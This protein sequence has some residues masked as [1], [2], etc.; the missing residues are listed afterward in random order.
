M[1]SAAALIAT[2]RF[3]FAP[4][5][6]ELATVAREPRGWVRAQLDLPL[7]APAAPLPPSRETVTATLEAR[8]LKRQQEAQGGTGRAEMRDELRRVYL[9]EVGARMNAA[10]FSDAPLQERLVH[11]WSN[12][13]TV[14]ALRPVVRGFVGA[15]E[16]EAIRPHVTGRFSDMLL[17]VARHPAMLF[18]LDNVQSIGPDS[19]VGQRRAKGLN[20]NL[21]REILELHTL[22]VDGGYTQADVES[23]AR[24]LTGW[25]IARPNDPNP[26]SFRFVPQI[27]EP[28]AKTL[29][30]KRYADDG[31]AEGEAALRDLARHPATA[32]HIA[33]KLAIHFIADDPPPAAVERIAR[34]FRDSDGDLKRVMQ[35]V[36]DS[37]EA[38][39]RPFAKVR[40][41]SELVIAACRIADL[42]PPPQGIVQSL[43]VLDQPPFVA[44][45]PAG[46]PDTASAWIS[47]ESVVRRAEW[48]QAFADRL[49]DPPD[50]VEL[51]AETFGDALPEET[52]QAIRRAPSRRVGL[53]LLVAA[54]EFQRR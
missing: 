50:P 39:E 38:W 46:W 40:T 54:P 52:L 43:R 32:R 44:P 25:T 1:S 29:L 18:Y 48:A 28:G 6:G 21:A 34:A 4:R 26:G 9:A 41:P 31:M 36:I 16:R 3:G 5:R 53:A 19:R 13:F 30:G 12:H 24:I 10:I 15:F 47:P 27:H 23:F 49:T 14:S 17:A 33:R 42:L 20:E 35:A 45:S 11:F 2:A 8:R 37:P 51:A 22:G 7:L